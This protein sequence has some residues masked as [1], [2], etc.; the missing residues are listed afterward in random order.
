M[1]APSWMRVDV[2]AGRVYLDPDAFYPEMLERLEVTGAPDQYWLEVAYLFARWDAE[3]FA[4]LAGI[5]GV[6]EIRIK[7]AASS[8]Q[9]W[10]QAD[11]RP[12]RRAELQRKLTTASA[13]DKAIRAEA[14]EL[15][16]SRKTSVS[17]PAK[18]SILARIFGNRS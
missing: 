7:G 9:R 3:L 4:R 5:E 13:V 17:V 10:R 11:K 1:E 16:K 6:L 12:G 18:Q 15:Y 8:K 2:N 14:L